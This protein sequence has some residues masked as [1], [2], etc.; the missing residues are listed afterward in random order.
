MVG[1]SYYNKIAL[2]PGAYVEGNCIP[3][4]K[5]TRTSDNDNKNTELKAVK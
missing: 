1:N 5:A 4:T 3:R 2:E